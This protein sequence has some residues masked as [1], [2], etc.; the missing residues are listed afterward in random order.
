MSRPPRKVTQHAD[1]AREVEL[2]LLLEP[3]AIPILRSL[4]I[5]GEALAKAKPEK[6][7]AI[8]YD[9]SDR[10]LEKAGLTLRLRGEA[11]EYTLT[12]KARESASI[13]RGE[14]EKP[15]R[16][17]RLALRDI[18][19]SPA[20]SVLGKTARDLQP[21]FSTTVERSKALVDYE[22]AT[23]ELAL[24]RGTITAGERALPVSELEL[25]LKAGERAGLIALAR[26][27]SGL[28][29]LRLSFIA[30]SERGE[31]LR[32][33]TWGKPQR[34]T[35]PELSADM[36]ALAGFLTI[37]STC[38]HDFMLN[39]A[40][41]GNRDDIEGVHQ[42]R[43]AIRRLRAA[44]AL[45]APRIKDPR[46]EQLGGELK[47]LS[48]LLGGAR[49]CDV[50]MSEF[51]IDPKSPA[52]KAIAGHRAVAHEA[53]A[54][55]LAS[56]RMR[57]LLIDLAG[58]LD[59][60]SWDATQAKLL[61]APVRAV[62]GELLARRLQKLLKRARHLGRLDAHER[63]R[64]RIAAK[65]LRYMGEFFET[66]L[67]DGPARKRHE[68]LIRE[69]E[70]V[71]K[72]LGLLQDEVTLRRLLAELVGAAEAERLAAAWPVDRK[73]ELRKAVRAMARLRQVKPF[74]LKWQK[75]QKDNQ[76]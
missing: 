13:D 54:E 70:K 47:W 34:A 5:I 68:T 48:D 69:L 50:M 39:E 46:T 57:L 22:S 61:A 43:I 19:A 12:V 30:K 9:T 41:I 35:T 59:L 45:F 52:G 51:S 26:E 24:D 40:A 27:L 32:A 33:G 44:F 37:A 42:A 20:A 58:A 49:D 16:T 1:A 60:A 15:V 76:E 10:R 66:L 4:P 74:W 53:L 71:Q 14:W 21:L 38:L 65:K 11:K 64:V 55:G 63:H 72:G 31:R 25:E 73:S 8:Y 29:P 2:K 7:A 17:G 62:A 56:R 23:I 3:D 36:S 75:E 28:A 6:L 18:A 67:P